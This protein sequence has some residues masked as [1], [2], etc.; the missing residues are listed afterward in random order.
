MNDGAARMSRSLAEKVG[1]ILGLS[2]HP[3][4]YQG[5]FGGAK[6][7]WIVDHTD[8][9]HEDWIE[10]YPS[11]QKWNRNDEED[12]EFHR[13]FE[14]LSYSTKLKTH[15]VNEQL[16]LLLMNG[17]NDKKDMERFMTAAMEQCLELKLGEMDHALD[18]PQALRRWTRTSNPNTKERLNPNGISY[19][20]SMPAVIEE[21]LNIMLDAHFNSKNLLLMKEWITKLFTRKGEEIKTRL[22]IPIARSAYPLMVP[23]FW[24]VLDPGEVYIDFSTFTDIDGVTDLADSIRDGD[25][26]LVARK[27]AHLPS[28]IQ[29]VKAV[30]RNELLGMK[31]V[32][33]FSTKGN[34]SLASMLSGGDYDGDRAWLC[35]DSAVVSNFDSV[36][37]PELPDLFK[38][39]LLKRDTTTYGGLAAIPKD[40]EK[41]FLWKA[42]TFNMKPNL[43]PF[44]TTY[45]E[46]MVYTT[47]SCSSPEMLC[48]S[49][50][51]SNL[52]DRPKQG[53]T[54]DYTNWT[55][56][57]ESCITT[58]THRI[59][60]KV[61]KLGHNPHNDIIDRLRLTAI[62][63]VD[64]A[65]TKLHKKFPDS[66]ELPN[67]TWDEDLVKQYNSA[68]DR[69]TTNSEWKNLIDDL[70]SDLKLIRTMWIEAFRRDSPA[71]GSPL[72]DENKPD[73]VTIANEVFEI[74]QKIKPHVDTPL[75]QALL[76]AGPFEN[77]EMSKWA[78]LK[79]STLF[80][81]HPR[82]K[83]SNLVWW[84]AFPQLCY[85]KSQSQ[86]GE[87]LH[88][89]TSTTWGGLKPDKTISR[90]LQ[91]V[92]STEGL[93]VNDEIL[94]DDELDDDD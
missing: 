40:R 67:P 76:P 92:D 85:I 79:A 13:T 34:P 93:E 53:I 64:I 8:K 17:A 46:S 32:I 78:L 90:Q 18:N 10:V 88:L 59:R 2:Y 28:D 57:V 61:D 42:L 77:A 36:P 37:V 94:E 86:Q 70:T 72:E 75:T 87:R 23:D 26:V 54:F 89:L 69:A 60:P 33:V 51:L 63:K 24:G 19:K 91:G 21:R 29:K 45:K 22:S 35:W 73:F 62:R 6:G 71:K 81:S 41:E 82:W 5:R 1:R 14:V 68:C 56:F 80:A 20:V 25:H 27:P 58:R 52:V 3:T 47:K 12:D 48:I 74:Y 15:S 66:S 65:L 83:V 44:A 11:Q 84:V 31:D 55:A 49:T 7:L 38:M 43:L 4:A 30:R 9:S 39:G 50:L 16:L